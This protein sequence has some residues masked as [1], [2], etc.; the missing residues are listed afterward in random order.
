MLSC[1]CIVF[2]IVWRLWLYWLFVFIS[3]LLLHVQ[4]TNYGSSRLF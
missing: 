4:Q 1:S 2:S 3:V